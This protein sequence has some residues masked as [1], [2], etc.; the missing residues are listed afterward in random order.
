MR[1]ETLPRAISSRDDRLH[2][3]AVDGPSSESARTIC[4]ALQ[5]W[6]REAARRPDVLVATSATVR[7]RIRRLWGREAE[8]IHPPVGVDE[9]APS[10]AD[11]GYLLV[12]A[13]LWFQVNCNV[14]RGGPTS[15]QAGEP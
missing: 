2:P 11:D 10:D 13:R 3:P 14:Q 7:E 5:W 12:L 8:V 15:L 4:P 6:D 9:I 1:R